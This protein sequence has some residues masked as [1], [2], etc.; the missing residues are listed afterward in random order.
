MSVIF[1][2]HGLFCYPKH[3][4]LHLFLAFVPGKEEEEK[5]IQKA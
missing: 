2:I 1:F 5:R 4:I 3:Y